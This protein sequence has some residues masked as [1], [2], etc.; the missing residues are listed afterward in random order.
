M[1]PLACNRGGQEE[2]MRLSAVLI[3]LICSMFIFAEEVI[4]RNISGKVEISSSENGNWK[5]A[6]EGMII[7]LS[8]TVST[9][10]GSSATLDM[11]TS[12]VTL[13]PLTRM[14]VDMYLKTANKVS[15]SLFLQVGAVKAV[16]DSTT[17]K[18]NFQVQSPFSTASV[19]GTKF[20]FDGK[21]LSVTEGTVAL[22]VGKPKRIIQKEIIR[23]KK[24]EKEAEKEA[25]TEEKV[26]EPDKEV[27]EEE[28]PIEEE[29][30]VDEEE[31]LSEVEQEVDQQQSELSDDD[32]IFVNEGQSVEVVIPATKPQGDDSDEESE[33]DNVEEE[34]SLLTEEDTIVAE[35][36]VV[37]DTSVVSSSPK[38]GLDEESGASLPEVYTPQTTTSSQTDITII[39]STNN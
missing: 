32:A 31:L 4:L 27:I 35:S 33:E 10:F 38:S 13:K 22:F 19:R 12:K 24:E 7:E 37:A 11:G 16:V 3:L 20:E 8:D 5:Q 15:T 39:W 9:G 1:F 14:T 23:K 30:P 25:V 29:V 18:Q 21:K 26:E 36:T 2:I 17:V 28:I 6:T 34:V